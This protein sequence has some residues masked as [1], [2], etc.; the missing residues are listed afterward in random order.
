MDLLDD[1]VSGVDIRDKIRAIPGPKER[2]HFSR[3]AHAKGETSGVCKKKVQIIAS[4]IQKKGTTPNPPS[5]K[6]SVQQSIIVDVRLM[7]WATSSLPPSARITQPPMEPTQSGN[8]TNPDQ[9]MADNDNPSNKGVKASVS[10][11]SLLKDDVEADD[12]Q[13]AEDEALEEQCTYSIMNTVL[14]DEVVI[15]PHE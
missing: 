1:E 7:F 5:T 2:V 8:D 3:S 15:I 12:E 14:E 9:I 6:A 11:T 4:V 10:L 13:R